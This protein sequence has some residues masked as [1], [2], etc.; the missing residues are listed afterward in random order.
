ME[1]RNETTYVIPEDPP[2]FE[3]EFG[4]LG[5]TEV[6][7]DATLAALP[8]ATKHFDDAQIRLWKNQLQIAYPDA[9]VAL[10]NEILKSYQ[11]H[12][13]ILSRLVKEHKNGEHKEDHVDRVSSGTIEGAVELLDDPNKV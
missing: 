13:H 12:P 10:L 2:P 3:V 5:T 7:G 9:D 1:K 11:T 8:K 6:R 4:E